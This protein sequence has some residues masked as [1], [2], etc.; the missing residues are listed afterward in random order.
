MVKLKSFSSRTQEDWGINS[1]LISPLGWK[2]A[3]FELSGVELNP[4][5]TRR[6]HALVRAAKAVYAEFKEYIQPEL[7]K[8]GKMDVVLAADDMVPIFIYII[9]QSSL[10]HPILNKNLL[11]AICHADLLQGESGYYLTVYES[12]IE[13]IILQNLEKPS[14]DSFDDIGTYWNNTDYEGLFI[15]DNLF[16]K[17]SFSVML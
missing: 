10:K 12:A 3:I 16:R 11:W 15:D 1:D 6:L 4:T 9:C 2:T 17:T 14:L 5:P 13:Y 8:K 7:A